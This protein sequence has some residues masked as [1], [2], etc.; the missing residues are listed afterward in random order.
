MQ[1]KAFGWVCIG[2]FSNGFAHLQTTTR[3]FLVDLSLFK[4]SVETL[5]SFFALEPSLN[6]PSF[7]FDSLAFEESIFVTM[8]CSILSFADFLIAN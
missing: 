7:D 1:L 5:D 2:L 3:S 8:H 6:H 4:I